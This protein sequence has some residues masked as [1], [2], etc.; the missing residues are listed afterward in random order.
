MGEAAC[1]Q[2]AT[3]YTYPGKYQ[4]DSFGVKHALKRCWSLK[5]GHGE[6]GTQTNMHTLKATT[7]HE[8][9]AQGWQLQLLYFCR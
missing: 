6:A 3:R 9:N 2:V 4:V 8:R 5:V 1:W 7:E